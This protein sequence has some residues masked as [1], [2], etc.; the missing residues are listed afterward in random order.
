MRK[1]LLLVAL[2]TFGVGAK[3]Q[4]TETD[5]SKYND[6]LYAQS[7][8][9]LKGTTSLKLPIN[10]KA[11]DDITGT[12]SVLYLP[13]G[14]IVNKT[15][16]IDT[17][18]YDTTKDVQ[19][20]NIMGNEQDDGGYM[21]LTVIASQGIGE[22]KDTKYGFEAGDGVFAY[23][24]VDVSALDEGEYEMV[25]KDITISGF[26]G[27]DADVSVADPIVTKLI[28]SDRYIFDEM[29]TTL[30]P[31]N[32]GETAN[33]TVK[34][35]IKAD[36]WSTIVLPFKIGSKTKL[37]EVFGEGVE[38][39]EFTGF[40]T[41]YSSDEDIVPDA[42]T[43]SFTTVN[44]GAKKG[45][46]LGKL[47]IIKTKKDI[48]EFN[49]DGV[50]LT[51]SI[52]E[53]SAKDE[54]DTN[55]KFTGSYVKTIVPA[56]GLFLSNNKFYYS[57]GA[58]NIKG[59]RGWFELDAVLD[60]ET[61]FGAKIRFTIDDEATSIDGISEITKYADGVYS[62]TGAKVSE[63]SLEGLPAGVYIVNGKKVYKK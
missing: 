8:T 38:L 18:R 5:L 34:R 15:S 52:S 43:M 63:D 60:K 57:T 55:G 4:V 48:T 1:L 25:M 46:D 35:T 44:I 62:V 56:D 37:E 42:I 3:A 12:S 27:G 30:P 33:V 21:M 59:F 16:G 61:D 54:Y 49:V 7:V 10:L 23:I 31:F 32:P 47:Y 41:A 29:A 22:D 40:N 13:E 50:T 26:L 6:V 20:A 28:I 9:A 19:L 11:H 39:A 36:N 58:T 51:S 24:E 14:V 17:N 53:T 2:L 45:L